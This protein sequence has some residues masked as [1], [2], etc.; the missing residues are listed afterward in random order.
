MLGRWLKME[1]LSEA[2]RRDTTGRW[3]RA[4]LV[5]GGKAATGV[6]VP[7]RAMPGLLGVHWIRH[8][9]ESDRGRSGEAGTKPLSYIL[10][11]GVR[12]ALRVSE[13][14]WRERRA[15]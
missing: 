13:Q 11:S 10:L 1:A 8:G 15:G 3:P 6:P 2:P 7:V 4:P 5:W 12:P 14:R 9:R